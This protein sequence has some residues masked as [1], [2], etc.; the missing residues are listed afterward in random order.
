MTIILN[1]VNLSRCFAVLHWI[2]FKEYFMITKLKIFKHI[3]NN[4][5]NRFKIHHSNNSTSFL[6]KNLVPESKAQRTKKSTE[7]VNCNFTQPTTLLTQNVMT[8]KVSFLWGFFLYE[9]Y[10]INLVIHIFIKLIIF[11]G[12]T[13]HFSVAG[14]RGAN[15]FSTW[16][17]AEK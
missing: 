1:Y 16:T 11:R 9:I 6:G 7:N 3:F 2:F 10:S 17:N 13:C 14:K 5:S 15:P 8:L 4:N 12:R